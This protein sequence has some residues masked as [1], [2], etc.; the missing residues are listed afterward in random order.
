MQSVLLPLAT[1]TEFRFRSS[2]APKGRE[3][4]AHGGRWRPQKAFHVASDRDGLLGL[5]SGPLMRMESSAYG[6]FAQDEDDEF[7]PLGCDT[8][9]QTFEAYTSRPAPKFN[10]SWWWNSIRGAEWFHL[11]LWM[12]K[13]FLWCPPVSS[14]LI[15]DLHSLLRFPSG[16]KTRMLLE[17]LRGLQLLLGPFFCWFDLFAMAMVSKHG[18]TRRSSFG[19]LPTRGG[20][21]GNSLTGATLTYPRYSHCIRSRLVI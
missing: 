11:Y 3:Q 7:A 14:H 1:A 21:T 16:R 4:V 6:T 2:A 9:P 5:A 17:L 19:Y 18:T 13:D 12:L 8:A 15:L 20:C 10:P